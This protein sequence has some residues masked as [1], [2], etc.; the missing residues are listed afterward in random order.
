MPKF[1]EALV[2]TLYGR[3]HMFAVSEPRILRFRDD[4]PVL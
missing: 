2:V 3:G 4:S 1:L